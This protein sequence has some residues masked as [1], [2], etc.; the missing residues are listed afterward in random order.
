MGPG[1]AEFAMNETRQGST[2]INETAVDE[3]ALRL[4]AIIFN[5]HNLRVPGA[6]R[7]AESTVGGSHI[8][9]KGLAHG[10]R[11]DHQALP[12]A[13]YHRDMRVGPDEQVPRFS[14]F[15]RQI[16]V[17]DTPMN[18]VSIA[19][20]RPVRDVQGAAIKPGFIQ[21]IGPSFYLRDRIAQSGWA[22]AGDMGAT[23]SPKRWSVQ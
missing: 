5:T 10:T 2:L 7:K 1:L 15:N 9:V 12:V 23:A 19:D 6:V 4:M 20:P 22:R 18:S 21:M 13:A 8:R 3:V 17:A 14:Q 16:F 11:I